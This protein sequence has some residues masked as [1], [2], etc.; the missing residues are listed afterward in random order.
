M[1]KISFE[2]STKNSIELP[3]MKAAPIRFVLEWMY[4]G[5]CE[6]DDET[7][8]MEVLEAACRLQ[9]VDLISSLEKSIVRMVRSET[10]LAIWDFAERMQLPTLAAAAKEKAL[11]S[12]DDLTDSAEFKVLPAS[13]LL[14]LMIS[15]DNL[16][17]KKEEL[18]FASI[19]AWAKAQNE[20]PSQEELGELFKHV[21]FPLMS[22]KFITK[23]VET[24][25]L[26]MGNPKGVMS[27]VRG[28]K[29]KA[30]SMK[31]KRTSA[32]F[33]NTISLDDFN[34]PGLKV[35]IKNNLV[36]VREACECDDGVGW[37]TSM[38]VY[39]GREEEYDG[40]L[41]TM[42]SVSGHVVKVCGFWWP[43][44]VLERA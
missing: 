1:Q 41:T 40:S 20:S 12:F 33:G 6:L 21:R 13:P 2:D 24:E 9:C 3:G 36:E 19:I 38:S 10:C 25:K 27:L 34:E 5:R 17:T 29:E 28:L 8:A 23:S 30:F 22:A 37:D 15:D 39:L 31:T 16:Y 44:T 32:R 42:R 26:L 18:V 43:I 11:K 7:M 4:G 14:S 35:R